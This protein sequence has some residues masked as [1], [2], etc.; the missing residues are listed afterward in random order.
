MEMFI[1]QMKHWFSNSFQ[2]LQITD[3]EVSISPSLKQSGVFRMSYMLQQLHIAKSCLTTTGGL[4]SKIWT[5]PRGKIT[6]VIIVG[7]CACFLYFFLSFFF[8]PSLFFFSLTCGEHAH[9]WNVKKTDLF[10]YNFPL[11]LIPSTVIGCFNKCFVVCYS[12][13]VLLHFRYDEI[14]FIHFIILKLFSAVLSLWSD[15]IL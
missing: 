14:I 5:T 7:G 1:F 12:K 11:Q 2:L 10:P 4:L 13:T 6:V 8:S 15:P 3:I 9:S